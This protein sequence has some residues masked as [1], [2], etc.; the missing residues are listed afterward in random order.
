MRHIENMAK[1]MLTTGLI[2]A[3]GYADGGVHGLVQRAT[4]RTVP[5]DRIASL[6]RM[7]A[8]WSLIVCNGGIPQLLWFKRVRM[9]SPGCS[10]F[11]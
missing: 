11:R 5:V 7:V 1:I 10:C 8:D 4:F 2:V 3:Y 9:T 6:A